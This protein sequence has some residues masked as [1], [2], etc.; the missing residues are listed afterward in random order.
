MYWRYALCARRKQPNWGEAQA[1][2]MNQ[3]NKRRLN[4]GCA[5]MIKKETPQ[6]GISTELSVFDFYEISYIQPRSSMALTTRAMATM[7]AASRI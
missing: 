2:I 7:Y 3:L 4:G 6:R 5:L 1:E